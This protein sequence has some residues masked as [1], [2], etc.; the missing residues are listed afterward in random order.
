MTSFI[1]LCN[2]AGSR[3]DNRHVGSEDSQMSQ[4]KVLPPVLTAFLVNEIN[5]K[6][7]PPRPL[8]LHSLTCPLA[9][10]TIRW[11]HHETA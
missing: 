6:E 5:D 2:F 7:L 1:N 4:V 8:S 3:I 11:L 10:G 9:Y